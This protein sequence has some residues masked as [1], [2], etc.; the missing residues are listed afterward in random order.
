MGTRSVRW[1]GRLAGLVAILVV[2]AVTALAAQSRSAPI[3]A[4]DGVDPLSAWAR[5][6]AT[7]VNFVKLIEAIVLVAGVY[8]LWA[9]RDE[10]RR[11]DEEAARMAVK[12]ANY[13]AWQVLNS[14][15]GKGGNGGRVDAI[16]DLIRNGVSLAGVRLDGAW[17]EDAR[18]A[19][20]HFS[21]ASFRQA[22][23][24]G[25]DLRD[26]NLDGADFTDA[27]LTGADLRGVHLRHAVVAGVH[28]GTADLRGADLTGIRG[29]EHVGSVSYL[30]LEGVRGAPAGF[31]ERMLSAG[32]VDAATG[33]T[34]L[35]LEDTFSTVWRAV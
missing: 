24:K 21:R 22:N 16:H 29:W 19:G 11:A 18:L 1:L 25:A 31:C 15:Q 17:L 3:A 28:L 34:P 27:I 23:L 2:G 33:G 26:A 7:I 5:W 6:L 10:R 13:Q 9:R 20:G 35:N 12:S 4:S 30:N 14:A 8:Q 32:A